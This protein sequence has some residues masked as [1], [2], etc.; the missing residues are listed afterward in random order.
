M[1]KYIWNNQTINEMKWLYDYEIDKKK[2]V[3]QQVTDKLIKE[4]KLDSVEN[5]TLL[6][7]L[8]SVYSDM[9][10]Y[11]VY[12]FLMR[13]QNP[14]LSL[15]FSI[16]VAKKFAEVI[17]DR[18]GF[19][20]SYEIIRKGRKYI[21]YYE[22]TSNE[23]KMFIKFIISGDEIE[24]FINLVN[25]LITIPKTRFGN[26]EP[27]AYTDVTIVCQYEKLRK[28]KSRKCDILGLFLSNLY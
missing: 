18:Y 2:N 23:F 11:C 7:Y 16:F 19:M 21:K 22:L 15:Y 20:T 14:I 5:I 6:N 27:V 26:G 4:L 9:E 28:I 17:S 25:D 12:I 1:F 8:R 24:L 13:I 10:D 3:Y